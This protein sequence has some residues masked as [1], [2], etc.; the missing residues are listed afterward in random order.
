MSLIDLLLTLGVA[1]VLGTL[2]QLTSRFSRGGWFVH[3][4][5]GFMGGLAGFLVSR[6]FPVPDVYTLK[7]GDIKFPITWAIIGS[8]FFLAALG[9]FIK[10]ERR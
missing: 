6:S 2:A 4:G 9:F 3:L 1:V 8:V 10:N 5:A 7:I